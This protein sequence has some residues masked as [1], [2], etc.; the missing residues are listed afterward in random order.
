[1][2]SLCLSAPSLTLL[3]SA[4]SPRSCAQ[5]TGTLGP[6]CRCKIKAPPASSHQLRQRPT[7]GKATDNIEGHTQKLLNMK[8]NGLRPAALSLFLA[9]LDFGAPSTSCG[10]L[11][12]AKAWQNP[13][14]DRASSFRDESE[15]TAT[16]CLQLECSHPQRQRHP[17]PDKKRKS[18]S[19]K[20][21]RR[22]YCL[23]QASLRCLSCSRCAMV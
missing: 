18:S 12:S 2:D 17:T 3:A 13:E 19:S 22:H 9:S 11:T 4:D 8:K 14:P 6:R 23:L 1:M 16:Q 10:R 5:C 7:P 21:C 20:C 15:Q